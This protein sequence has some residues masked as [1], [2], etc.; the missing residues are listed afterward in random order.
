MD[1]ATLISGG[2][3]S[4]RGGVIK[5]VMAAIEKGMKRRDAK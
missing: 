1:T 3:D 2:K 4:G 5:D